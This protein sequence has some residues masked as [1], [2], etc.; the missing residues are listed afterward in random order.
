MKDAIR[1]IILRL[2]PELNAGYHLPRVGVVVGVCDTP[3][4]G[5]ICDPFRPHYAVNVQLLDE[6]GKPDEQQPQMDAVPVSIPAAGH[7]SGSWA[8]PQLGTHVEICWLYGR[9]HLPYVRGILPH[10]LGLPE[11]EYGDQLWQH[12]HNSRQKVDHVGN[13][14]RETDGEISDRSRKHQVEALELLQQL[15]RHM[16]QVEEHSTEEVGGT[17]TIEALGAIKLLSGG[18]LNVSSLEAL[19]LTTASEIQEIAGTLRRS[20]AKELQHVEVADGGKVWLGNQSTNIVQLLLSLMGIVEALANTCA[21]HT[22]PKVPTP[23]QAATFSD[24]SS[25]AGNLKATLTPITE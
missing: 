24:Q 12:S 15:Q 19:N 10:N 23:T 25:A 17:K 21:T 20:F 18:V 4:V 11:M 2:F 14:T 9:P 16:M 6:N 1:K 7:E 8:Y 13:W 3:K 22:H 5:E